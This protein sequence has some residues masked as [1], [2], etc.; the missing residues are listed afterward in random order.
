MNLLD[1]LRTF[2]R[3]GPRLLVFREGRARRQAVRIGV[4]DLQA[5]LAELDDRVVR[6]GRADPQAQ[7]MTGA[8]Y[9]ILGV[10]ISRRRQG[11]QRE[12][13]QDGRRRREDCSQAMAHVVLVRGPGAPAGTRTFTPEFPEAPAPVCRTARPRRADPAEAGHP[14]SAESAHCPRPA[15][16]SRPLESKG[17]RPAR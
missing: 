15:G 13:Q 7:L 9:A 4:G 16:D 12:D 6:I 11:E 5:V 14:R 2:E 17:L 3:V 1:E 10:Q 8:G